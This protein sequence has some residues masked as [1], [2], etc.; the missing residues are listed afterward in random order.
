MPEI[1][2]AINEDL[3]LLIGSDLNARTIFHLQDGI[4]SYVAQLG[5][6]KMTT[7]KPEHLA[8]LGELLKQFHQMPELVLHRN[9]IKITA[10]MQNG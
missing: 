10:E 2:K 1:E 3:S 4:K 7:H 5:L 9:G 6:E 8:G